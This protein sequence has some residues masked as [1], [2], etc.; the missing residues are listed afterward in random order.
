MKGYKEIGR[1]WTELLLRRY[2]VSIPVHD[3]SLSL[4][5]LQ[6]CSRIRLLS[7]ESLI[8]QS[9]HPIRHIS[10]EQRTCHVEI[11]SFETPIWRESSCDKQ[12]LGSPTMSNRCIPLTHLFSL[13]IF[14][15]FTPCSQSLLLPLRRKLIV[16]DDLLFCSCPSLPSSHVK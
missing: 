15:N 14:F 1:F 10:K 8:D 5:S 12:G 16:P 11:Q 7:T 4:L 9:R 2:N 6:L 3:V 13:S